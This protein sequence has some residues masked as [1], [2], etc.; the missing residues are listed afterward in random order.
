[1]T[2]GM[3]LAEKIGHEDAQTACLALG[4]SLRWTRQAAAFA[5]FEKS[6]TVQQVKERLGLPRT[7]AYRFYHAWQRSKR[8]FVK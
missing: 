4:L 8:M 7:T 2:T 6:L 1:M 3:A 5:L